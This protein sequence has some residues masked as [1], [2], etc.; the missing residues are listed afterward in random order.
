MVT[1]REL[2]I[3]LKGGSEQAFESIYDSNWRYVRSI[4]YRFTRS[5]DVSDDIVQ[6]VFIALWQRC[7][8]LDESRPVR[9]YIRGI[10]RF[11]IIDYL[12][13]L[14][15]AR[16]EDFIRQVRTECYN[17]GAT[18]ETEEHISH[19]DLHALLEGSLKNL[20]DKSQLI[21]RLS[22]FEQFSNDEIALRLNISVKN[23]EYHI[24]KALDLLRDQRNRYPGLYTILLVLLS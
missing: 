12:R 7:E 6:E 22:R 24:S 10:L 8:S 18:N 23:V 13:Q 19:N 4:A 1:E 3:A 20:P 16:Q 9:T 5:T 11:K 2:V 14:S 17:N 21:F 15:R